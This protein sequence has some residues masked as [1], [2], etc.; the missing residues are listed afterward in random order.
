MKI[1]TVQKMYTFEED[2]SHLMFDIF[3]SGFRKKIIKNA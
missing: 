2:I 1:G 3:P